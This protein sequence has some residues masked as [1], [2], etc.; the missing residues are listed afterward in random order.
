MIEFRFTVDFADEKKKNAI[1]RINRMLRGE[2]GDAMQETKTNCDPNFFVH[3]LY[4]P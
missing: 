2:G 4:R 3:Q 1:R